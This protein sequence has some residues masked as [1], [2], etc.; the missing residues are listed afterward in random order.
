MLLMCCLIDWVAE[1]ETPVTMVMVGRKGSQDHMGRAIPS[2]RMC[3]K[4]GCQDYR[5]ELSSRL[6]FRYSRW[7]DRGAAERFGNLDWV[8]REA[9][10]LE[11]FSHK[12]SAAKAVPI[13]IIC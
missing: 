5:G 10:I 4:Y 8:T 12:N 9:V 13:W 11:M 7:L 6:W 3:L 2:S 1:L